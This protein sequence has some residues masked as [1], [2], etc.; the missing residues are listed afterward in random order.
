MISQVLREVYDIA[1]DDAALRELASLPEN[2]RGKSFERLRATHFLRQEFQHYT[3]ELDE[4]SRE[5][6][7]IFAGIGF[8]ISLRNR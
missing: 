3:V 4:S 1:K 6:A 5:T 7:D 2:F 8:N